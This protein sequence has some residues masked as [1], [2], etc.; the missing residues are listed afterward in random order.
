MSSH[1]SHVPAMAR[2]LRDHLAQQASNAEAEASENSKTENGAAVGAIAYYQH[3]MHHA[4][5]LHDRA[6][7]QAVRDNGMLAEEIAEGLAEHGITTTAADLYAAYPQIKSM[8]HQVQWMSANAG[9]YI[10][11]L[12]QVSRIVAVWPGLV[13]SDHYR[14]AEQVHRLVARTLADIGWEGNPFE[15]NMARG[16]DAG[17]VMIYAPHRQPW[18]SHLAADVVSDG[19]ARQAVVTLR[20]LVD[21]YYRCGGQG[22]GPIADDIDPIVGDPMSLL[23]DAVSDRRGVDVIP[24]HVSTPVHAE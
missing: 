3:G 7:E 9:A 14:E 17:L 5:Q 11:L 4:R 21:A 13:P 12:H 2:N 16:G 1:D 6:L 23:R 10:P 18:L 20:Q 15:L 22:T 19:L 24:L 8:E